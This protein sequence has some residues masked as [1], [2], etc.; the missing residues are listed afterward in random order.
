MQNVKLINKIEF[1][2]SE[3][4]IILIYRATLLAILL[5]EFWTFRRKFE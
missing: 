2:I 5:I 4:V 3:E 1:H